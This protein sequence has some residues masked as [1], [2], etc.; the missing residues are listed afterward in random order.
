[1]GDLGRI[2]AGWPVT[3]I[4]ALCALSVLTACQTENE[5]AAPR[6]NDAAIA[7]LQKVNSGAQ[8]CWVKSKDKAFRAYKVIPELDTRVG[9]PRILIVDAK[10]AQGLPKFVIEAD[11]TP[12]KLS[13]YGPL[14]SQ[15]VAARINTDIAR[16]RTGNQDCKA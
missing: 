3:S 2:T 15:P 5:I 4:G 10:A 1:M 7:L 16:W 8:A 6:N 12:A 9:K 11:G 14:A 13:T